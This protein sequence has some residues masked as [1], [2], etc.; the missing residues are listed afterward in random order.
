MPNGKGA[1]SGETCCG[2]KQSAINVLAGILGAYVFICIL[3]VW[4]LFKY[5]DA[6]NIYLVFILQFVSN[7][8]IAT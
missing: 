5:S 7:L 6:R 1:G 4:S 8:Y 2:Q 3:C